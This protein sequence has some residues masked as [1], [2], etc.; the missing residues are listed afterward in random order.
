MKKIV[1]FLRENPVQ[2]LA[3]TGLDGKPKVRPFQFM[4][5]NEGKLYFCT[6]N[7]KKV[8]EELK[9]NPYIELSISSPN[10]AWIRING[11]VVFDKSLELKNKIIESSPL[12]KS[13][14][15]SANNPDFEIFYINE[16]MAEINDFSINPPYIIKL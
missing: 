9:K 2:Y 13:I 6:S 8:Y 12:V 5:E 16:G 4:L 3:T 15:H 7:K 10:F 1:K 14:Y 11:K